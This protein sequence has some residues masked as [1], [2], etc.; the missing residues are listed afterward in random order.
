METDRSG[1]EV[2]NAKILGT[3]SLLLRDL[4]VQDGSFDC[5]S[6]PDDEIVKY[7]IER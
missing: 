2:N 5:N 7:S 6:W 3:L 4:L 1:S